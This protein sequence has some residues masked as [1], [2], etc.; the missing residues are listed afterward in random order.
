[1]PMVNGVEINKEHPLTDTDIIDV[2][3]IKMAFFLE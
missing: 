2:G 1:M 3:G